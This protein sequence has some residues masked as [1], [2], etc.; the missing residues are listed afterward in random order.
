MT[1]DIDEEKIRLHRRRGV[2]P[3]WCLR[4]AAGLAA[5][6]AMLKDL[7]GWSVDY[8]LKAINVAVRTS[9]CEQS[10][11]RHMCASRMDQWRIIYTA[12]C[13]MTATW[14]MLR[15]HTA[16]LFAWSVDSRPA[17]TRQVIF[18]PMKIEARRR[19]CRRLSGLAF[20]DIGGAAA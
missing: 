11:S 15:I 4:F 10:P 1:V 6:R 2:E 9:H 16:A 13:C 17:T 8:V 18:E 14:H 5:S 7:T 12:G 3:G 19:C 20:D